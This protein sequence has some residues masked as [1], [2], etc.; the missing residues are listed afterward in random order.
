MGRNVRALVGPIEK[1]VGGIDTPDWTTST[2]LHLNMTSPVREKK[3]LISY[4]VQN[5]G[6]QFSR[7][8]EN[9]WRLKLR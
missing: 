3:P 6:I 1:S 8:L 4:P 7:L 5:L 9:L 2:V